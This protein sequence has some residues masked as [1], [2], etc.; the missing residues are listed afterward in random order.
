MEFLDWIDTS[1]SPSWPFW[2]FHRAQ[3]GYRSPLL[4][5][6][7][8]HSCYLTIGD[9]SATSS[10]FAV[11]QCCISGSLCR[12]SDLT[13]LTF[14]SRQPW[15]LGDPSGHAFRPSAV[16]PTQGPSWLAL[17]VPPSSTM[18]W[19]SWRFSMSTSASMVL[20]IHRLEDPRL[21]IAPS[22]AQ[23]VCRMR[24]RDP[25]DM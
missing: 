8:L 13:G 20:H 5:V 23:C 24:F 25:A 10:P 14:S 12:P 16:S 2:T 7:D 17:M 15:H 1:P 19:S 21:L 11:H 22:L 6:M 18:V 9:P 4:A 3:L